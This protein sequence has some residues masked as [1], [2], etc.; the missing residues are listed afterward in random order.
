[1]Y[2]KIERKQGNVTFKNGGYY[3]IREKDVLTFIRCG[4]YKERPSQADNLH[5]D[6]WYKGENILLDGGSYKYNTEKKY[7]KYLWE[8]NLIILLCL[9]I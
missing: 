6:I 1:M 4:K 7:I 5:I 2:P 9:I 3:I 8:Q